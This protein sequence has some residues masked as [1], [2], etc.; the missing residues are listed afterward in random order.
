MQ[1]DFYFSSHSTLYSNNDKKKLPSKLK[2]LLKEKHKTDIISNEIF[3]I[4][5]IFFLGKLSI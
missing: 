4:M 5:E 3:I 1:I 2:S